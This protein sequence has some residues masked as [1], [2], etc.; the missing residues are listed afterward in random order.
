[1]LVM[2][3]YWLQALLIFKPNNRLNKRKSINERGKESGQ[4]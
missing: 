1:M 3:Y 4:I 2:Q